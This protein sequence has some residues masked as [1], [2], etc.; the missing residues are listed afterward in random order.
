MLETA[1]PFPVDGRPYC[2]EVTTFP[3]RASSCVCASA[4]FLIYAGGV[5]RNMAYV[6]LHR[7]YVDP[8]DNARL[9]VD[10]SSKVVSR[11]RDDV[12]SY[13][14][15]ME[16]PREFV[17]TMFATP[18]NRAVPIDHDAM[19]DRVAGYPSAIEEWLMAKCHIT[20]FGQ[21]AAQL[22]AVISADRGPEFLKEYERQDRARS[23]CI[24]AALNPKREAAAAGWAKELGFPTIDREAVK[25][26][27][28]IFELSEKNSRGK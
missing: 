24:E 9:D 10:M 13:L 21:N 16:I 2:P 7:P 3:S 1:A 8:L 6:L 14:R 4:C 28:R 26:W 12:D 11:M 17:D 5:P 23:A 19:R 27:S 15:Q 20:T 25:A 18:S 22:E